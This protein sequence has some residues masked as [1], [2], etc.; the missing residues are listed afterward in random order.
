MRQVD[1][2]RLGGNENARKFFRKNGVDMHVKIDKKYTMKAAM[3]YRQEL[4]KLV[5][6]EAAKRGEGPKPN[7]DSNGTTTSSLLENLSLA[8]QLQSEEAARIALAQARA[9]GGGAAAAASSVALASAKTAA[10]LHG[11]GRLLT[12][13]SSGNAPKIVLRAPTNV[14]KNLLKKKPSGS[15]MMGTKLRVNKLAASTPEVEAEDAAFEDVQATQDAAAAVDPEP[16]ALQQEPQQVIEPESASVVQ[17]PAVVKDNLQ[18]Q[19]S[20]EAGVAKLQQM[21][22]NFFSGL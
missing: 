11:K 4:E 2:M 5:A 14:S 18:H 22:N 10:E 6:V 1:A 3:L 9:Q 8:E 13:P 17:P 20:M 16:V 19:N 12:P 15:S 7:A 21:N